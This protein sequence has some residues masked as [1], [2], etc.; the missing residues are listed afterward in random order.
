MMLAPGVRPAILERMRQTRLRDPA[1]IL[2]R[3]EAPTLLLWGE[4]DGMIPI[5]NANDYLQHLPNATMVS[6]PDLGHL[7]F[8]EDP[9]GSLSPV[10]RF[11]SGTGP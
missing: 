7:P 11:L 8:E 1:P 2:A 3:I 9:A 4:K 10:S 5:G 6:L